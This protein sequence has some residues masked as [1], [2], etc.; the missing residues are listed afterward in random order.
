MK[1]LGLVAIL[2][3]IVLVLSGAAQAPQE[4]E[5]LTG[6][7][8]QSARS[9]REWEQRFRAIPDPAKMAQYM[10][11]LAARPHAV[12]QPWDEQNA[13]YL[14]STF[15]SWGLDA[16]IETFYVLFPTPQQRLLEMVEPVKFAAKLEEP[17]VAGDPT[18]DQQAEQLP[19]YNAYSIDGDVT[20][21]L[22]YVNYGVP[23]DYDKLERLG[24]SVKGAI[25]LAR[26][27]KSWRGIKPK[28]AAEHG[29]VGC[30]LYSDPRD[31]GYF[32]GDVF[33][34]GPF[35]PEE[36]VQR[37]SVADMPT[38]VGD[39]LT[40]GYGATKDAKRLP[41]K[42]NPL[43]TKIPVLPI[44]Y[45][46]ALPLLKDLGGPVAPEDWRGAL[47]ITY[48]VGPGPA[49]VHLAMKSDWDIKP[50][51]DVIVKIPGSTYPD[52]WVLRG[53]HYD[54]WVN[55][56]EDPISGQ[57]AEMEELRAYAELMK[58][59]WKPKR[60]II[61]ASW[62]GEEP[63]L[64]GST[65]WAEEH[66]EEL[67]QHAVAYINSDS[68]SRGF[69][70]VGGSHSLERL[71]NDAAR[72]VTDPEK[73]ISVLRRAELRRIEQAKDQKERNELRKKGVLHIGALGSG[74]DYT[75]FVDHLGIASA[76]LGFG[77]EAEGGIYHSIYDDIYWY[78][79]FGDP[80]EAYG[81]ALSQ[82]TG[83]AVMRLADA[84]VLPFNFQS[85][86]ETIGRYSEEVQKL[87][88]QEREQ[89]EET[90]REIDEGVFSATADPEKPFVAPS[91]KPVPPFLNFA[92]LENGV[93]TLKAAA[94][95]YQAAFEKWQ[96]SGAEAP[97]NVAAVNARLIASERA[98]TLPDGLP[99][100]PWFKHQI[101]APGYYTGY[102]VKTLPGVREAIEQDQWQQADE[103]IA[104]VH[105]VLTNEAAVI[106]E[107]AEALEGSAK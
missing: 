92:P 59:G 30:I 20:A 17:A 3:T 57:V 100:R 28:V 81:R 40:P 85:L 106:N 89:A 9:E 51:N 5:G 74:S 8:P 78:R 93:A 69:L 16:H 58:A 19:T 46:D 83:T 87:A 98:L 47:G 76:N 80:Q 7:A 45:A 62:D 72:E 49:K 15:R 14:L 66:A 53:N 50:V 82:V 38:Y 23:E 68:N 33:P 101:Y 67:K 60:T 36:G 90:N 56:A 99:K 94:T 39:P 37:G 105:T 70:F 96:K 102:G 64:L 34:K 79:H 35:R 29:A 2:C 21:P 63:G 25:V 18:S 65:E 77:G 55:G 48:H 41:I 44:S 103:Q 84:D 71:L 6:Y 22:V 12:G 43:I 1:R 73:N 11:R 31:D 95:R 88:K 10:D 86:A 27:G 107:A 61:Y 13:Q 32:E 75:V 104:R 24:I 52:E 54:A 91:K 26:Y 4:K 97:A 42:D